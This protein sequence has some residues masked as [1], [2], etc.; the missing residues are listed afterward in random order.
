VSFKRISERLVREAELLLGSRDIPSKQR[1]SPIAAPERA[2]NGGRSLRREGRRAPTHRSREKDIA[3]FG[4]EW[5]LC[6]EEGRDV[7]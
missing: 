1:S 6:R 3:L 7:T 2:R 4:R 5:S